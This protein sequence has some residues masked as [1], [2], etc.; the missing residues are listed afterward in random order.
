MVLENHGFIGIEN[1]RLQLWH[2]TDVK[3]EIEQGKRT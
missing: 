3:A 2:L 1:A